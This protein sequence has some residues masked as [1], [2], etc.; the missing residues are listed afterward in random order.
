MYLGSPR[1]A[2]SV[3]GE[4]VELEEMG[5]ARMHCMVSGVG[6]IL[7][8]DEKS[9]IERGKLYFSYMPQNQEDRL[10]VRE[11]SPI[12]SDAKKLETIIPENPSRAYDMKEVIRALVDGD[13]FFEIKELYA[14]EVIT[15]LARLE[16]RTIGIVA[17]QPMCKAGVLFVE[18]SNKAARFIQI[19]NNFRIPLLFLADVPGFMIGSKV[20][21]EGIIRAGAKMVF[22]VSRANVPKICLL[23]RKAYG[24]GLYAMS[25]PAFA[26]DCVLA[27]PSGKIAIMGPEPAINAVY[28]NKMAEMTP[29]EKKKFIEVKSKEYN[30]EVSLYN[31]GHDLMIDNIV[32]FEKARKEL[33]DR[34]DHYATKT[35]KRMG[36]G[37]LPM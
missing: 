12:S 24:A 21:R 18:S 19:C 29:E 30:D 27:L 28:Y 25:G 34:F 23:V 7:V 37:I 11:S 14:K 5:G 16:G 22:S 3:I 20:E 6:D 10:P 8:S 17:N 13:S 35:G 33:A 9:A 15:G 32:E 1:M 4:K 2:E 31:L 36:A 26:S